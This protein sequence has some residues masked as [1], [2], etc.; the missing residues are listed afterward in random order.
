MKSSSLKIS[1]CI[2]Q[3]NRIDYLIQSL[4]IIEWQTYANIEIVVSDDCS[5]DETVDKIKAI[6]PTY[7]FPLTFHRNEKNI[8]YD[9]NY[10]KCIEL[11]TG[12]YCL[13]I[14][15]DDSV[16]ERDDIQYLVDFLQQHDL[17][18]IGFCNYVEDYD[19]NRII[20]RAPGTGLIGSGYDVA[21]KQYSCF[22]FVGGL[23]YKRSEFQKFNTSKH[24]GSI[25]AQMYLGC[26][27]IASG[28]NLFSIERP[29]VVKD[30]KGDESLRKSY[31]DVVARKWKDHRKVDGGLPSVINVLLSA[32]RD[33][34]VLSQRIVYSIFKRIYTITYAY[35]LLDYRTLGA[36]P[37]SVGMMRGLLPTANKNYKMLNMVNRVRIFFYYSASSIIGLTMPLFIYRRLKY[38]MYNY[39]KK[40]GASLQNKNG[41]SA[42]QILSAE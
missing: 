3:Y 11:A 5:T 29:L 41:Q 23:I 15:N 28:C 22:S 24:D 26:L 38:K 19:R 10:R 13:V 34:N 25:Y 31:K 33:A 21:L 27:M 40:G 12:E 18:E 6:Q 37:E 1:I 30:L 39:Y 2:P 36:Y 32:F 20:A 17:P 9:A 35:W 42:R 4:R 16:K 8:G 14:G 7:R